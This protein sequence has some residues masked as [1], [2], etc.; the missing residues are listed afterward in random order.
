MKK[1]IKEENTHNKLFIGICRLTAVPEVVADVF[2]PHLENG[3]P[4]LL[5]CLDA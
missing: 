3:T 1:Y 2:I 5:P 4:L